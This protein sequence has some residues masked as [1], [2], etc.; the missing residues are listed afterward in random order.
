[1]AKIEQMLRLKYIEE[2]LRRKKKLG[3][4]FQEIKN[5]L[6]DKFRD[7]GILEKLSFTNRTFQRDKIAI[8]DISGIEISYSKVKNIYYISNEELEQY[9]E[10]IF[11]NL[12][13]IEAYREIKGKQDIMLF[14]NRKARG[15]HHLHG[16]IY[17]ITNKLIVS[18]SYESFWNNNKSH[19][20]IQPYALKEFR[21]RWYL[22]GKEYDS[23]NESFIMKTY[24]LDR[25]FDLQ[26]SSSCFKREP[27]DYVK[28]FENSFGVISSEES[29]QEV[30]LS[31]DK[32]QG[33]YIKAL[34][35]HNS[36]KVVSETDTEVII[37]LYIIPT[38]DFLQELLSYGKRVKI[39][40]PNS[41]IN[42][43]KEEL[44]ENL[45]NYE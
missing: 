26:I 29:P 32:Q 28:K 18:F 34:P 25:I 35:L 24:G 22:L 9:E 30:L 38:Y 19:K 21:Y 27:F 39:I 4:S 42:T 15:L 43:V 36:Q 31:F 2:L 5:Y 3:A 6:E 14:E 7:K 16:L 12:L 41:L 8:L 33:N 11:D 23:K 45:K 37:S 13:L 10:N 40:K 44:K 20:I 17:A 1:M